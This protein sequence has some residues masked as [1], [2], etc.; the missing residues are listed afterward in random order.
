MRLHFFICLATALML[1]CKPSDKHETVETKTVNKVAEGA[2]RKNITDFFSS[3][4][5]NFNRGITEGGAAVKE[6][7]SKSFTDCFIESIP[8]GVMCVK[9]DNEFVQMVAKGFL[10]YE[11][12]GS[13]SMH[14]TSIEIIDLDEMHAL[15]KV[16]WRYTALKNKSEIVIDFENSYFLRIDENGVR[17]FGYVA[18]DEQKA[19]KEA[20]LVPQD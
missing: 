8:S 7:I 18:G 3:Y 1:A 20:G 4:E 6:N 16:K 12:I 15:A 17:I 13:K 14:V 10:F 5:L 19:L 2:K 11:G 9:N